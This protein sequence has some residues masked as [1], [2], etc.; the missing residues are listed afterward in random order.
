MGNSGKDLQGFL[1]CEQCL[2]N[3]GN[4]QFQSSMIED[5]HQLGRELKG[6]LS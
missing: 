6:F 2:T 3:P 1:F 4:D 5:D